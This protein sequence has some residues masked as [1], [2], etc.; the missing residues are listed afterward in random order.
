M[1]WALDELYPVAVRI[2]HE[3]DPDPAAHGVR[4]AFEVHTAGFF[5][6]VCQ[7]VKVF[8]GEGDV[9]VACPELVGLLLVVVEGKLQSG[10]GVAWHGEE[11][12][13][14]IIADRRLAGKLQAKLV[15][16]E[17]YAPVEIQ[18]PVAGVYVAQSSLLSVVSISAYQQVSTSARSS[19]RLSLVSTPPPC[20]RRLLSTSASRL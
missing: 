19:L 2:F 6:P 18:H 1:L 5:Q 20:G 11:G 16:V 8:D 12:V 7:G 4:L 14:R 9:A 10:L 3:E 15:R 13:G 17:I